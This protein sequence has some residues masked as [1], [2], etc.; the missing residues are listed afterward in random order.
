MKKSGDLIDAEISQGRI[1][2]YEERV[3][4]YGNTYKWNDKDISERPP[5]DFCGGRHKYHHAGCDGKNY[6]HECYLKLSPVT[7]VYPGDL[8]LAPFP[9]MHARSG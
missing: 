2:T 3:E 4:A 5:C 9:H 1:S 8:G 6:C 7:Q